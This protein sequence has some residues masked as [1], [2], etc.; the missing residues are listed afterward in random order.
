MSKGKVGAKLAGYALGPITLE[1]GSTIAQE[2][3]LCA[4]THDLKN[5]GL[6]LVCKP[7]VVG[8]NVFIGARAFILPGVSIGSKAIIGA[9]SVVTKDVPEATTVAGNPA[10]PLN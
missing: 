5:P 2:A 3:Y 10:K 6:P 9:M 7:I 1:E 8:A 4:G